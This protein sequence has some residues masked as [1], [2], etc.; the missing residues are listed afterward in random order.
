MGTAIDRV[1]AAT[2]T[3]PVTGREASDRFGW[4]WTALFA[5]TLGVPTVIAWLDADLSGEREARGRGGRARCS[6]RCTGW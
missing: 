5:F 2:P 1:S 3:E 6:R 4:L